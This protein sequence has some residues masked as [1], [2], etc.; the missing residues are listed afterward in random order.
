MNQFEIA[1][2]FWELHREI[3]M[4]TPKNEWAVD[5]YAWD[6]Y[7]DLTPIERALWDDIRQTTSVFY[8]QW[9]EAGFFLDFANPRAKVCLE[10][11]GKQFHKNKEKDACRDAILAELGWA[12]YRFPGWQCFTEYDEDENELGEAF[13]R[14]DRITKVHK[15]RRDKKCLD[16]T[17]E[18]GMNLYMQDLSERRGAV[19]A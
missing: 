13:Q 3:I 17:Y 14:L 4:E 1:L 11:D 15:I 16:L 9:P 12:V 5:P 8:P 18:S 2:R 7:I 19:Y 10:C 6:E